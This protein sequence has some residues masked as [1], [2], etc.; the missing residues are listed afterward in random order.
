[1]LNR[2]ILLAT[3]I[4]AIL[5]SCVHS[6]ERIRLGRWR[7]VLDLGGGTKLPFD[8]TASHDSSGAPFIEIHNGQERIRVE[9]IVLRDD[10]FRAE[11][12][13]FD[14]EFVGRVFGDSL[15]HGE[16]KNRL[17]GDNYRIP[18]TA[19]AG[20]RGRFASLCASGATPF[21]GSWATQ[22]SPGT[23]DAYSSIGQFSAEPN[24][25]VTG[26]FMT[27]TGDYRFLEGAACGDSMYLS[28][29]DGNHAF[30]FACALRGDSLHGRFW[31][32]THWQEPWVATRDPDYRLRDPDSLT[33]LRDGYDRVDFNFLDLDGI[34]HS[35]NDS[36]YSG[37]PLI[38]HVMGSWCPNC[39]D[40]TILL[41]ELYEAHRDQ[42]LRVL[43]IAFE[44]HSDE[45]RAILG[46][47][48]FKEELH[49]PYPILYGGSA[50]KDIAA[51]RLPFLNH[52]MS[53]PTCIF[54]DRRG[55]VRRIRTGFYGPG[56]GAHYVI[57]KQQLESFLK[58]LLS[59]KA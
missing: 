28:G 27:E 44:K 14:S 36:S 41:T 37:R 10:S 19:T 35:P 12:P 25:I 34:E 56:T 15:I 59:E 40:E 18:F 26:T 39:V 49:V 29:F 31:S 17:K 55:E 21:A 5:A 47:R 16:W 42:G 43:A 48:R 1:M 9:S 2:S 22:F 4:V 8:W 6:Q 7:V 13:L 53:Y 24:G 33:A 38:V 45:R 30:L 51:S 3:I 23:P 46:L 54:I 32:G 57:Y 11:M 52:L 58:Q 50:A 20:P